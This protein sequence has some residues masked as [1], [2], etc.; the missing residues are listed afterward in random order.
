MAMIDRR[1]FLKRSLAAGA[2]VGLAIAL[3]VNAAPPTHVVTVLGTDTISHIPDLRKLL[4]GLVRIDTPLAAGRLYDRFHIPGRSHKYF[5]ILCDE[6]DWVRPDGSLDPASF[7]PFFC[8]Q[9]RLPPD[10]RFVYD[11][12][13]M[14]RRRH[15]EP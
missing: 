12:D 10:T 14:R 9:L 11:L 2:A 6:C 1:A 13:Y 7:E 15:D 4:R 5:S 8:E 3:P